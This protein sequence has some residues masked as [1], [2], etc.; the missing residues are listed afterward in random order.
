MLKELLKVF[1]HSIVYGLTG[2]LSTFISVLLIPIYTRILTP[3]EYGVIALLTTLSLIILIFASMGM[4]TAVFWAYFNAK[5]EERKEVVFTAFLFLTIFPLLVSIIFYLSSGLINR[6][7]FG[8]T[9]NILL[10]R[11]SALTIFFNAGI[12]I[13]LALLRAEGKPSKYVLVTLS[14]TLAAVILSICFVV[15]LRWGVAGAFWASLFAAIFGY[16]F[17][18]L[19]TVNRMAPRFSYHWL[20]EMLRFGAPMMP[21]GLAMWALNS[22]D[23]YFLNA[24]AGTADVG[25]YYVGYRVG[26]FVMLIV[27]AFQLAY[28]PFMFSIFN[29]RPNPKEYYRKIATYYFFVIFSIA[30]CLSI[31][32]K[33]IIQILTGPN[34]HASYMVVPFAAY[35]YVAFGL[36]NI[37]STG[38]SVMRKTYLSTI[39]VLLSGI[40][41]LTL[42]FILISKF[43]MIGAA[44]ATFISFF[45]LAGIE[46]AF[47]QRIY[48]IL[49][50]FRRFVTISIVG[51][52]LI[53]LASMINLGLI[54]SILI[55]TALLAMFPIVLYMIGFFDKR[56]VEIFKKLVNLVKSTRGNPIQLINAIKEK[57]I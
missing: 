23:R 40:L 36:Y 52:L 14:Q 27:G 15:V 49:Y 34:F 32:G 25:I 41:N 43:G 17:S 50:E 31:F 5:E 9:D 19:F 48:K 6:L 11:L 10:V 45:A 12:M 35:S 16:I 44:I 22:S 37:F 20:G 13:P 46:L 18:L 28:G 54:T 56:E 26:M 3:A 42:N 47:S 38:V 53:V 4:G 57:A 8:N 55:K 21:A 1:G 30:L 33:E 2:M 7:V 29:E 51:V 39:S 24:F